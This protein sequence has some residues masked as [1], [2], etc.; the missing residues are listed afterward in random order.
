MKDISLVNVC[1]GPGSFT[2]VRSSIAVSKAFA[3]ANFRVGYLL[4]S[5]DNIQ[6]INKI[7][8][9]KN[10]S[11]IAQTAAIAALENNQYM[12]EYVDE[13][14]KENYILSMR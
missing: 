10:L 1:T 9:P 7:R 12:W 13:V 6:F 11:T 8:N 4:A 2:G 3:L 14:T 5:K